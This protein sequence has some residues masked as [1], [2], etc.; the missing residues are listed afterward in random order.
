MEVESDSRINPVPKQHHHHITIHDCICSIKLTTLRETRWS[1]NG[2]ASTL[3]K[4]KTIESQSIT[5]PSAY[6]QRATTFFSSWFL[7]PAYLHSS[8]ANTLN[9]HHLD[10]GWRLIKNLPYATI[11]FSN[12]K[13]I[14]E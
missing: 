8:K 14:I 4:K 6:V 10:H 12:A 9:K 5:N 2:E 1:K 11:H 7:P 3:G 13:N